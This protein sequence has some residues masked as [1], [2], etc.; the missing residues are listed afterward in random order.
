MKRILTILFL[1]ISL[2]SFAQIPLQGPVTTYGNQ[3]VTDTL[4]IGTAVPTATLEVRGTTYFEDFDGSFLNVGIFKDTLFGALPFQINGTAIGK[5]V[6]DW[7]YYTQSGV[8]NLS[9]SISSSLNVMNVLTGELFQM[10]VDSLVIGIKA[11]N[12]TAPNQV[13]GIN[14]DTIGTNITLSYSPA[15][16]F[17]VTDTSQLEI[18]KIA[19][20]GQV[21]I[22]DGNEASGYVLTS[23]ASGNASWQTPQA[24]TLYSTVT[25]ATTTTTD[26]ETLATYTVPANTLNSDGN[27]LVLDFAHV[28]SVSGD[29]LRVVL[30]SS[31]V[32][33]DNNSGVNTDNIKTEI[34]RIGA[35]NQLTMTSTDFVDSTENLNGDLTLSFQAK[36]VTSGNQS[37]KFFKVR[38]LE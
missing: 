28:G 21:T 35:S 30:G 16:Y 2:A 31:V 26:W 38:R 15:S 25:A 12:I 24:S 20:S 36:S 33:L 27:S 18:F 3:Y 1:L 5:K 17:S 9:N 23:D 13:N 8:N 14:V 37:L 4:G 32:F 34:V 11:S 10:S 19:Q 22:K 6:G 29:S 7:R